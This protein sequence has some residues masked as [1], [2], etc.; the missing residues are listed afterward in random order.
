MNENLERRKSVRIDHTS[1]I[2]VKNLQSG[3]IYKAKMF[4]Y[5]KNGLYFE[6]N[7]VL[8]SGDQ[9]YIGVQDSPYASEPGV[10]EYYRAQIMWR[11]KLKDSY[12]EYGYGIQFHAACEKRSPI[13]NDLEKR[14]DIRKNQKKSLQ[15]TIK[16]SDQNRTYDGI[17]KD[18]SSSG[19]F[20]EADDAFEEGQILTFAVPLKN[21]QKA[22]IKGQIVWADDEGF[23]VVFMNNS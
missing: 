19:V 2:K 22:N 4:N 15:K 14:K 10:L 5:S 7:S 12:F 3:K 6:S 21:G 16:V 17:I 18:I 20:F 11:K 8:H 13:T 23:G 9:I 1:A